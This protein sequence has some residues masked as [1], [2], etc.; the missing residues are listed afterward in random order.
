MD[1]AKK[2]N[3]IIANFPKEERY[4]LTAQIRSCTVSN[5]SNISERP[6]RATQKQFKYFLEISMGSF[7]EL[8]F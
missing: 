7:N 5:S 6:G 1:L 3:K 2:V 8:Q 4:C